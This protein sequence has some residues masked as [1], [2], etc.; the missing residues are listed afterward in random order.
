MIAILLLL[1]IPSLLWMIV[2]AMYYFRIS[3]AFRTGKWRPIS[4]RMRWLTLFV[5]GGYPV[6]AVVYFGAF[7]R[8]PVRVVEV[9]VEVPSYTQLHEAIPF[10]QPIVDEADRY[11]KYY[12]EPRGDFSQQL[13]DLVNGLPSRFDHLPTI[14][15]KPSAPGARERTWP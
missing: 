7:F 12:S 4:Q 14:R 6:C 9:K 3:E 8:L 13:R 11:R 2:A 10:P 1:G 15:P 5:A